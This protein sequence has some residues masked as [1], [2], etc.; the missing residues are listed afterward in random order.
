MDDD[1]PIRAVYDVSYRRLVVQMTALCGN[2]AEAE[3]VVQEAFVAALSHHDDFVR[4]ANPEAWLRTVALNALRHRWRRAR[5][6]ARVLPRV[7]AE[8]ELDLG[9]GAPEDHVALV[10]ALGRLGLPV[11]ITVVLHY[12]ADLTVTQVAHELGVPEGTVKARLARAR[13]QLA[14]HLSDREEADHV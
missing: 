13:V 8:L 3:D 7:R 9:P 2:L 5:V 1:D 10:D 12:I 4:V 14:G 11:R 6:T